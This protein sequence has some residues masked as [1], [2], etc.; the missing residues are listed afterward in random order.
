MLL[1]RFACASQMSFRFVAAAV[2]RQSGSEYSEFSL[3]L[4]SISYRGFQCNSTMVVFF[5]GGGQRGPRL[6]VFEQISSQLYFLPTAPAAALRA[7][8]V[9]F[10]SILLFQKRRCVGSWLYSG[11][12]R[13]GLSCW[14]YKLP[15]F[16]AF[17]RHRILSPAAFWYQSSILPFSV[18]INKSVSRRNARCMRKASES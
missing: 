15:V 18:I 16:V 6:A 4:N 13:R 8:A 2:K 10:V 1:H 14:T 11:V 9:R 12:D 17:F 5:W 3:A 7:S